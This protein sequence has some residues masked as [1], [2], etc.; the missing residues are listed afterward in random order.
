MTATRSPPIV[1]M[2][3]HR[4]KTYSVIVASVAALF[5]CAHSPLVSAQAVQAPS[6][7]P[8]HRRDDPACAGTSTLAMRVDAIEKA[9]AQGD[10]VAQ[11]D[12]G[13][14][15]WCGEGL[16]GNFSRAATWYEKAAQ[17]GYAPSQ[18]NIAQMYLHGY[19]VQRNDEM[20]AY[21]LR[22]AADQGVA[23]A[24][25]ELG[26]LYFLGIGV[27]EDQAQA[28]AWLRKAA[29][30]GDE[31]AQTRLGLMLKNGFGVPR[32]LIAAYAWLE[33]AEK[34]HP[35]SAV[36]ELGYKPHLSGEALKTAETI[37]ARWKA[38]DSVPEDS[39]SPTDTK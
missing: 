30:Q 4:T 37:A 19:G 29:I 22:Q 14:L 23:V 33:I 38:G 31:N 9:A 5:L 1:A 16:E 24:Q 28:A 8:A 18:F 21:W 6:S 34:T 17:Q 26:N 32:N 11:H 27:N 36:G 39:P 15:Y 3:L 13:V 2:H 10:R 7:S 25:S 35:A 20:G 12:L